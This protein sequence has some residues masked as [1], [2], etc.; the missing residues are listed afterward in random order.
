VGQ[1]EMESCQQTCKICGRP[2]KFDFHVPDDIW[3]EVVGEKFKNRVVCLNCFDDLADLKGVKYSDSLQ[4]IYFAG[5]RATFVF[6]VVS[7]IDSLSNYK[8]RIFSWRGIRYTFRH[9][10]AQRNVHRNRS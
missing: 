1:F 9:L 2:D 3:E 5:S 7:S 4:G 8:N 6:R 10:L